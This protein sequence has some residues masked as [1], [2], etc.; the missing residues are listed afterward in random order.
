[1][2]TLTDTPDEALPD[3]SDFVVQ[4]RVKDQ[5]GGFFAYGVDNLSDPSHRN[6][7]QEILDL[8]NTHLGDPSAVEEQ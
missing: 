6:I 3:Q 5:D 1:L 8:A 2:E 7:V 4:Y